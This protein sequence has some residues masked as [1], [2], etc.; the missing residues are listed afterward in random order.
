MRGLK[1]EDLDALVDFM[2]FGEATVLQENLEA[3]M[4]VTAELNVKGMDFGENQSKDDI[5]PNSTFAKSATEIGVAKS[6]REDLDEDYL[7]SMGYAKGG[8]T[9]DEVVSRLFCKN[10]KQNQI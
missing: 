3:F 4:S 1:P 10:S 5:S 2:Y 8:K 9:F 6:T 7:K